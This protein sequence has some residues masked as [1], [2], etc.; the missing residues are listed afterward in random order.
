MSLFAFIVFIM[1]RQGRF[2]DVSFIIEDK[3]SIFFYKHAIHLI[4]PE[5]NGV[6]VPPGCCSAQKMSISLSNGFKDLYTVTFLSAPFDFKPF[7]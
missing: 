1:K 5:F 7:K 4:L 2:H 6:F 3:T